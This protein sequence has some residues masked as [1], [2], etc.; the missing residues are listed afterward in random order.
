MAARESRR[1][2]RGP[3]TD[4]WIVAEVTGIEQFAV[5]ASWA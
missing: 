4:P 1:H 3:Q 5:I 2:G